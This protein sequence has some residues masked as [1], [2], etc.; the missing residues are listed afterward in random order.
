M[1][2]QESPLHSQHPLPSPLP[3]SSIQIAFSPAHLPH[4]TVTH[5][6]TSPSGPSAPPTWTF[7]DEAFDQ[8]VMSSVAIYGNDPRSHSTQAAVYANAPQ[9]PPAAVSPAAVYANS[10]QVAPATPY[11]PDLTAIGETSNSDQ[12][13]DTK[14]P[15]RTSDDD[16]YDELPRRVL[17]RW[18]EVCEKTAI[19]VRYPWRGALRTLWRGKRQERDKCVAC[20]KVHPRIVKH[21]STD[22]VCSFPAPLRAHLQAAHALSSKHICSRLSR[23]RKA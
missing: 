7:D 15:K 12:S 3:L 19:A 10:P 9:V 13:L 17:I 6:P 20:A 16:Y 1:R 14:L 5:M 21:T 23:L 22:T 8:P 2:V 11:A 18:Q 4:V